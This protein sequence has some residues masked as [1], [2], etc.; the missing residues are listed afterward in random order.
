MGKMVGVGVKSLQKNPGPG[1][2]EVK[3]YEK[4]V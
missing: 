1:V 4:V 3:W 2:T